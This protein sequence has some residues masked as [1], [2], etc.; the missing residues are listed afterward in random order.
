MFGTDDDK[1]LLLRFDGTQA[2][3]DHMDNGTDI[4]PC[5]AYGQPTHE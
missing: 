2:S 4:D 1:Y 5:M 3:S